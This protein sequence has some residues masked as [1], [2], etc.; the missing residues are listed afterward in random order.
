[1]WYEII[2]FIAGGLVLL[3]MLAYVLAYLNVFITFLESGNI[4]Y[5]YKGDSL[6]RIIADVKEKK[7]V[8]DKLVD[9]TVPGP[10][11]SKTWLEKKFGIYWVGVWPFY[12]VRTFTI[13]KRKELEDSAG[14]AKTEWIRNL[15]EVPVDSLRAV[16][17]RPFLLDQAELEDRQPVDVLV[18]AKFEVVDAYIPVVQLKGDF[19]E[20]VSSILQ[21]SVQ[22]V[23]RLY[24]LDGFVGHDKGEGGMLKGLLEED[25]LLNQALKSRVGL[26]LI[27]IS[28]AQWDPSDLNTRTALAK[29]FTAEKEAEATVVTAE[30]QAKKITIEAEATAVAVEKVGTA[31]ARAAEKMVTAMAGT[32]GSPDIATI[33]AATVLKMAEAT[34]STSKLTTLVE[35]K[36]EPVVQVGGKP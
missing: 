28:I 34:S 26:R 15:G 12:S 20:L 29:R 32:G 9:L 14:K 18:V 1:M 30:A 25:G 7:L 8:D 11:I 13:K 31:R 6:E 19:F 23:L 10:V 21:G 16:F 24:D 3:A 35:G 2:G 5:I 22:D 36:A 17:P 33:S 27:G 4:K